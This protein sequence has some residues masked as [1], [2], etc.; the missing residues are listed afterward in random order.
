MLPVLHGSMAVIVHSQLLR[1]NGWFI[2]AVSPRP[3]VFNRGGTA[4]LDAA[5]VC[6]HAAPAPSFVASCMSDT[7]LD[8]RPFRSRLPVSFS[9]FSL[10]SRLLIS[11]LFFLSLCTSCP[12][13]CFL[14]SNSLACLLTHPSTTYPSTLLL[15]YVNP[16]HLAG[17]LTPL[18]SPPPPLP[19]TLR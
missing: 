3:K 18:I 13:P 4:H 12:I 14:A 11:L 16:A 2:A 8:P 9:L 15:T 7:E 6:R 17:Y 10:L 19:A 1:S 5:E